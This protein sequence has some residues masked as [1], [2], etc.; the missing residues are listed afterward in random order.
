MSSSSVWLGTM[1]WADN[2][3]IRIG[4][5]TDI[6]EGA[7]HGAVPPGRHQFSVW[8]IVSSRLSPDGSARRP[9]GT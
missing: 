6:Q 7:G 2:E 4:E 1:I 3:P 8:L 5:A 9:T